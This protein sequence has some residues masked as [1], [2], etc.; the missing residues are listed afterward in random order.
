MWRRFPPIR[1]VKLNLL[2]F[3]RLKGSPEHVAQGMALGIFI[4]MTPTFGLQMVI[5]AG[6][7]WV[8]RQNKLAAILGVWITNPVTAP[9]IYALE[10]ETGRLILGMDRAHLPAEFTL[11]TLKNLSWGILGPMCLGSLLYGVICAG[12]AYAL[13]FRFL[14]FARSLSV[15]R[16]PRRHRKN[17]GKDTHGIDRGPRG[18]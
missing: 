18:E 2:K 15:P 11:D 16:W 7:A 13:T 6:A 1:Q 9:A 5:A 4:G 17:E 10:Y 3:T 8:L 14:P 12:I